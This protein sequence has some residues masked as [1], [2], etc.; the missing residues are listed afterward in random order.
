L[1]LESIL[2]IIF[3]IM[4]IMYIPC[5]T[6]TIP[7]ITPP[8]LLMAHMQA[9]DHNCSCKLNNIIPFESRSLLDVNGSYIYLHVAR[10][11]VVDDEVLAAH[12]RDLQRRHPPKPHKIPTGRFNNELQLKLIVFLPMEESRVL[13]VASS[14]L[15]CVHWWII[16]KWTHRLQ[17][18]HCL[19]KVPLRPLSSTSHGIIFLKCSN[20][21]PVAKV[22][23][24][25]QDG[26]PSN[27]CF[28][29]CNDAIKRQKITPILRSARTPLP[30]INDLK[31]LNS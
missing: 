4:I 31:R 27:V 6:P 3:I 8:P 28:M 30:R 23:L 12:A 5:M 15:F 1:Q 2:V 26:R 14:L 25:R 13:T 21:I 7:S 17:N 10:I 22:C 20:G 29:R 19:K 11:Y 9:N 24:G 16:P 18:T